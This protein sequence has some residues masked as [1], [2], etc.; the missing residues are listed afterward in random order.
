M[1]REQSGTGCAK[2]EPKR[3]KIGKGY[4]SAPRWHPALPVA[5]ETESKILE[6]RG[7]RLVLARA[8][9]T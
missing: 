3:T 9:V 5:P 2:L 6:R 7:G 1:I 8:P 4:V